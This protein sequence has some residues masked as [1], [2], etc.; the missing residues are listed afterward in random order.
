ML[1]KSNGDD[2]RPIYRNEI[3]R[4]RNVTLTLLGEIPKPTTVTLTEVRRILQ[5]YT[6]E[7][8][9]TKGVIAPV[10]QMW[11]MGPIAVD[12]EGRSYMGAFQDY[13]YNRMMA[14]SD[15]ER[16]LEF[17][18]KINQAFLTT[19]EVNRLSVELSYGNSSAASDGDKIGR[20]TNITLV[21][22]IGSISIEETDSAAHFRQY[23]IKYHGV[24]KTAN[25]PSIGGANADKDK[26]WWNTAITA[27]KRIITKQGVSF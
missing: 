20:G 23:S 1:I 7:A 10:I 19:T 16:L 2:N 21:G 3:Y 8:G 26:G 17:Q 14:D 11:Y 4:P 12:I 27:G 22:V 15:I 25:N 6:G 18:D 13:D 9:I 5:V 24:T